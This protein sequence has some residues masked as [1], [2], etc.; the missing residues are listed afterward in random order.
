MV[1]SNLGRGKRERLPEMSD[2]HR[3]WV[4][5]NR[6]G[7]VS[8]LVKSMRMSMTNQAAYWTAILLQ[9]GMDSWPVARRIF[10]SSSEDGVSPRVLQLTFAN[11]QN[12]KRTTLSTMEAA[13]AVAVGPK[14]YNTQW[15]RD[16]VEA[17]LRSDRRTKKNVHPVSKCIEICEELLSWAVH[18]GPFDETTR[19]EWMEELV[20]WTDPIA[21]SGSEAHV[22]A[23]WDRILDLADKAADQRSDA[24]MHLYVEIARQAIP[25][26]IRF[27]DWNL[28]YN[29]RFAIGAG[30][31]PNPPAPEAEAEGLP[32]RLDRIKKLALADLQA[33]RVMVPTWAYD[34]QHASKGAPDPRFSG[35]A[36]GLENGILMFEKYGRLDPRD[37]GVLI[38]VPPDYLQLGNEHV[39]AVV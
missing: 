13:A 12:T 39:E 2:K 36:M 31:P 32:A 22:A 38:Q 35:T 27:S 18:H 19:V 21:Q 10:F 5:D 15:G 6:A 11:L 33:L 30:S 16:S 17:M 28:L 14:W 29:L 26:L 8:A 1:R 7:L 25:I 20:W 4:R 34:G 23:H 3:G 9:G 24:G 37:Q